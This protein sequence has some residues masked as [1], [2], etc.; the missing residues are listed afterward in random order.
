VASSATGA[1][2]DMFSIY[3]FQVVSWSALTGVVAAAVALHRKRNRIASPASWVAL[4]FG[5][6][7]LIN[8]VANLVQA[9]VFPQSMV[10]GASRETIA[11]LQFRL[12]PLYW[13]AL[14]SWVAVV[15]LAVSLLSFARD[16]RSGRRSGVI[17]AVVL[18]AVSTIVGLAYLGA[19]YWVPRHLFPPDPV[20]TDDFASSLAREHDAPGAW[21]GLAYSA[22]LLGT[23]VWALVLARRKTPDRST[24]SG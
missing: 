13:W 17:V 14:V 12:I 4:G 16:V 24:A 7:A 3:P 23:A 15:S 9:Y 8:C 5:S 11:Y 19:I 2:E 22:I 20:Y 18:G 10:A 1:R 21:R 6:L